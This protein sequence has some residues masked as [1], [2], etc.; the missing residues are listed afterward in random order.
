MNSRT[1]RL[2]V[3]VLACMVWGALA[4]AA[5]A[6]WTH[7]GLGTAGAVGGSLDAPVLAA[8]GVSNGTVSLN[9]TP[10]PAPGTGLVDYAVERRLLGDEVWGPACATSATVHT[11]STS[12][13]EVPGDGTWEWHVVV[14]FHSWTATSDESDAV[15]VDD[16]DNTPPTGE[17]TAPAASSAGRA[18][19]SV[20]SDASD[21]DS[22]V[23]SARFQRSVH[24]ANSWTTIGT[25]DTTAPYSVAWNTAAV[26]DGLYDLRVIATDNVGNAH[27]SIVVVNVRV[28]NAAPTVSFSLAGATGAMA[29]GGTVTFNSS[30]SGGFQLVAGVA[31]AGS[32]AASATFPVLA[33]TAWSTHTAE[34]DTSPTGGPYVSIPFEWSAGAAT[35]APYVVTVTD[36]VGNSATGTVTFVSDVTPPTSAVTA[37]AAGANVRGSAVVVTATATDAA[38][39]SSVQFQTS[40]A[41]AGSWSALGAADTTSPYAVTWDTTT[42]TDGLYDVRAVSTDTAGNAAPS[43]A[44]ANVL[45]DNSAPTVSL[46]MAPGATGAFKSGTKIYFKSNAAGSYGLVATVTDTGSGPASASFPVQATAGWTHAAQVVSTPAGGPFTSSTFS[47]TSGATA[48]GTYTATVADAAGNTATSAVT[49]TADATA[50]TGAVTAPVA[51][52]NVRGAAVSVTSSSADAT[53]GVASAQFQSSPAGAGTWTNL[54]VADTVTPYATTWDTTGFADGLYDL[55]VITTDNVGNTLTSATIANVRVDNTAPNGSVTAPAI[56]G[57]LRG[58]ISMTTDSADGGSGVTSV[59]FQRSPAGTNTWT[60]Q[61]SADTAAPYAV[62]WTTTTSTTDGLYDLRAITTDKSGNTFTAPVVTNLRVDN[63]APTGA[64][65]APA[66]SANVRG[67]AVSVTSS[68]ADAGSGVA[69]AQ[70]QIS[71]AG[72]ASWSNLGAADTASP[73]GTTWDTTGFADALYD[74]RVITTDA[75]GGV[76][77]SATIANVRV[78]NTAPTGA[79]TAPATSAKVKGTVTVTSGSADTGSGVASA[80]F[81][82]SAAGADTW[83]NIAV[84]DTTTPYSASWVTTGYTAGLYDVRVVTTDKAGNPFTSAVTANV[85]VDNTAPTVTLTM[86]PGSIG[87]FKSAT[88]IYFKSNAAGSYALVAT[89]TDAGSGPA[90]ASFPVQATAGWTHALETVST[91]AGGPF[92]S[93][94]F[95]WTSGATVPGTYTVTVADAAGNTATSAVTFTADA[96]APTGSVTAPIAAANVRGAAVS[97]TSSS[98]DTTSGVASAQFQVSPA[99]AATWS[100]LGAADTVTPFATT[101]DTTTFSEGLFDLRVIT[102][103][104]VGNTLTS[105]TIANVRVDN[106]APTGS[107]TAPA[108]NAFVSGASVAV[109]ATSAD[110]GSGVASVQFQTSP[111]DANTWTNLGSPDTTSPYAVTWNTT[112]G[113]PD[114]RYDLRM[115]TTDKA[116]NATTSAV[117]PVEVQNAAPTVTS[118]QLVDAGGTVGRVQPGD[119]IVVTYSQTLGVATLCSTWSG[120]LTAQSLSVANDVNVSL[121]DGGAGNDSVTV[122]SAT[123]TFHLGTMNLGATGY[124][125]GGSRTFSGSGASPA[126]AASSVAWDPSTRTLTVTLGA[127]A[128][129]GTVGTVASSTA[130]HTPDAAIKN[131]VG[132]AVTGTFATGAV[133]QF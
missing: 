9:W 50:P 78:D 119:R 100:N 114:G 20:T 23:A 133:P 85:L 71:N 95:S 116:G 1:R 111:R 81:Q 103:D 77:T 29:S 41:G 53:S 10:P 118:V 44:I 98:A 25:P 113:Y 51:A 26:S 63:T 45:V 106:T 99:G 40:P 17:I 28:D 22:G 96:T 79:I 39:V 89:V 102:T 68:S 38:G 11:A 120:N 16:P 49:F 92:T 36:A 104:N 108:S 48:P 110:T 69:T 34:T 31:D 105:A 58:A 32:G 112:S 4:V 8:P 88:K 101:W 72:T 83:S 18:T 3:G 14:Y 67:S 57:F 86:A 87:A 15:N 46:T 109:T 129:L 97:V 131:A 74:L 5:W 19:V 93:N 37:P 47:W 6:Y 66:A 24:G 121:T 62:T 130:T 65:T 91:P 52:A 43:P 117:L 76:T 60:N 30:A 132:T 59:Q 54:G 55:R 126:T 125:T 13:S 61:G 64:V 70:F 42:S 80:L 128:G 94:A 115:V 33:A 107:V 75:A 127:S 122:T 56:N 82:T 12:C 123:C 21:A 84:A 2:A 124:V 7:D 27:T 73:Y 90:S 35:P